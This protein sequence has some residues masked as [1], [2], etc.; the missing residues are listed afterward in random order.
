MLIFKPVEMM[1][2]AG[3]ENTTEY[4]LFSVSKKGLYFS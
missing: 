2:C 4:K 3:A 1:L